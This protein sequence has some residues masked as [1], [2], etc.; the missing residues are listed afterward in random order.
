[1][2][3]VLQDS[4]PMMVV[5]IR[6][7]FVK[8]CKQDFVFGSDQESPS[9]FNSLVLVNGSSVPTGIEGIAE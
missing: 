2:H 3:F 9:W 4:I 8:V 5:R 1:M 6:E 7:R